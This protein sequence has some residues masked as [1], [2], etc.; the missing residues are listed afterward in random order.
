MVSCIVQQRLV[1]TAT[2]PPET[3]AVT[4]AKKKAAVTKLS[5]RTGRIISSGKMRMGEM[6]MKNAME[7][8]YV[9]GAQ[10]MVR[11][12]LKTVLGAPVNS[13][14]SAENVKIAKH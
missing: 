9:S 4:H 1:T 5:T 3:D 11:N 8:P 12:V 10:T 14:E 7:G 13:E 2:R 6:M